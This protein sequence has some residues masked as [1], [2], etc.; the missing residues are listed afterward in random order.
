[1][2]TRDLNVITR[3]LD[4]I[5]EKPAEMTSQALTSKIHSALSASQKRDS[6]FNSVII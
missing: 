5:I 6:G 1:M 3:D 4:M 2:I